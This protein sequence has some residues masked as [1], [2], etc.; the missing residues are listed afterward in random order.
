[1]IQRVQLEWFA[2]GV[3]RSEGTAWLSRV[4]PALSPLRRPLRAV[5]VRLES[6][7]Q[8]LADARGREQLRE[9]ELDA[10]G[11]RLAALEAELD[12]ART[13]FAE[14]LDVVER[15]GPGASQAVGAFRSVARLRALADGPPGLVAVGD[16]LTGIAARRPDARGRILVESTLPVL[17]APVGLV[18]ALFEALLDLLLPAG[19]VTVS[20]RLE[21][22]MAVL[23]MRPRRPVPETDPSAAVALRA[24]RLLGGELSRVDGALVAVVPLTHVPGMRAVA[25]GRRDWRLP[26]AV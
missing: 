3:A 26:G 12:E 18:E 20:G 19:P 22:A 9:V 14:L 25:D 17:H 16:V 2:A 21:G 10:L 5:T 11:D 13:D 7:A 4:P 23:V 8:A 1:M 24:A 15:G 6:S